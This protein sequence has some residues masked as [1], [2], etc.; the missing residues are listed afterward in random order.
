MLN[1]G[2][3]ALAVLAVLGVWAAAEA[4]AAVVPREPADPTHGVVTIERPPRQS[5]SLP[6]RVRKLVVKLLQELTPPVPAPK[7]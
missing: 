2:K 1:R 4:N 6:T 7:P 3:R 5:D